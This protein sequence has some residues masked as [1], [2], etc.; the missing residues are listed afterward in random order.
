MYIHT[1]TYSC[2]VDVYIFLLCVYLVA[3][4]VFLKL[5]TS[6]L[7]SKTVLVLQLQV[8]LKIY[9]S[10]NILFQKIFTYCGLCG[11]ISS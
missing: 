1:H 6:G 5:L 10:L 9:F 3:C 7:I 8:L 2:Y 4:S 11:S